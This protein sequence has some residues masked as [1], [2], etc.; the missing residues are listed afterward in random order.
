MS[1]L[2]KINKGICV[3]IKKT[4]LKRTKEWHAS[5]SKIGTGDYYG[6]AIKN[7]VGRI[8]DNSMGY[9]SMNPKSLKKPPKAL[10]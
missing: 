9:Q 10:A 3:D 1:S 7:P 4:K 2:Q 6:R 8:R 5:N